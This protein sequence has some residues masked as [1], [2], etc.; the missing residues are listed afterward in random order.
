MSIYKAVRDLSGQHNTITIQRAY[1]KLLGGDYNLAVVLGQLVWLSGLTSRPDGY[2]YKKYDELADEV[3][4]SVDQVRYAVTKLKR[5]LPDVLTTK[6]KKAAGTPTTHYHINGDL[7]ISK[8]FAET[9][10]LD[11]QN[12]VPN[13]NGKITESSNIKADKPRSRNVKITKSNRT[14]SQMETGNLPNGN[15]EIPI[16]LDSGTVP[17]SITDLHT[18]L[19][20]QT[21]R[22]CQEGELPDDT[23]PERLV[24]DHLNAVTGHSFRE[25]KG[26]TGR[27]KARLAENYTT[28]DL[29]L[30]VDYLTAKW[31]KDPKMSDFLRCSTLFGPENC[32]EY[33]E[34]AKKWR[35]AGRPACVNGKWCYDTQQATEATPHW[36]SAEAWEDFI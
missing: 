2:F 36:N 23:P 25:G 10:D 3:C 7:L 29:I 21:K 14:G 34:F 17:K 32:A 26:T 13:G 6:V 1:V 33:F 22:S 30:V 18:D 4:L 8:L 19:D 31:L 15:G 24:L 9:D 35:D 27:I 20:K 12:S 16:S 5:L 28:E 11:T